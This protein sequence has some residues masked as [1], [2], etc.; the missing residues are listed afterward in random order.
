MANE[1]TLIFETS[2]PIPMTCAEGTGIAKGAVLM[3]SDPFT[4]ATTTGDTDVVFGIAA[5]EKIA[6]DGQ[7]RIPVYMSGIFRGTAGVAGVVAGMSIIS[8]TATSAV[9]RLVVADVNSEHVVGMALET[10]ASGETFLFQL[11]PAGLQLA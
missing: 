9:N 7:T 10:A 4:V 1:C 8:D 5:A 11:N 2:V 3:G 6:S